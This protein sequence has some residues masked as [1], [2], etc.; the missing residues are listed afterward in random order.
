MFDL[1]CKG[2]NRPAAAVRL[3]GTI[4][5]K[6]DIAYSGSISASYISPRHTS[7][8]Y[9]QKS[10]K[11]LSDP[12]TGACVYLLHILLQRL[13]QQQPGLLADM[14]NGVAHDRAAMNPAGSDAEAHG[15]EIADE[16][17]RMLRLM[18]AQLKLVQPPCTTG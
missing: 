10:G 16:A 9:E 6:P 5:P 12:R 17:L 7:M 15:C 13:E 11:L 2:H 8:T 4:R 18:S 1:R 14:A 3:I